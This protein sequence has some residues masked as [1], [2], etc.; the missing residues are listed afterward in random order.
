M[1]IDKIKI[2]NF[3]GFKECDLEFHPNINVFIGSNAS[4]KTTILNAIIKSIYNLTSN[5]VGSNSNAKLILSNDDINYQ[6]TYSKIYSRF[7]SFPNYE[8]EIE[9]EIYTNGTPI[10]LKEALNSS[11]RKEFLQKLN[12]LISLGPL[13]I[14]IVKFYPANRGSISY[15]NNFTNNVYQI[16]QLESWSNIYQ[17]DLSYSK[18]FNW[19]FENETNELRLQRDENSF[20]IQSPDLKNVRVAI[21]KVFE[22]LKFGNYKIV[23]K[24]EKRGGSSK[25]I[26]TIKLINL[27]SKIEED[28]SNKSDGEKAIITIV[29]D[30]AYNLSL[31]KDFTFSQNFLDSFGIVI[32]DEIETHLHPKWQR[33]IIPILTKTFPNIQFFVATHSP[34]IVSSV[35]SESVFISENFTIQK[36]KL[37]TKGEDTNSLLRFAFEST[38]RPK[39]FMDL[40]EKFD[41]LIENNEESS[42]VEE[43]IDEIQKL[44]NKDNGMGISN[45]IDELN[46]KLSAYLFEKEYEEN[47]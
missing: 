26:P 29:A 25:L 17:D 18:F 8:K 14:P 13:D 47:R 19:F 11:L 31:S 9:T 5:F 39:P 2:R 38:E 35:K 4:G 3:K 7:S 33:E 15:K 22:Y 20:E 41:N 44:Y 6:S 23:S 42:K 1:K 16:S 40:I 46:I 34:Q 43:V 32:I 30:I 24:Q 37:K 28:I 27:N 21:Y 10:E 45:L 36:A 12:Y